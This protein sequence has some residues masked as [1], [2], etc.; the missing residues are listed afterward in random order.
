M[1]NHIQ[2]GKAWKI[3]SILCLHQCQTLLLLLI[4]QTQI[5]TVNHTPPRADYLSN[6]YHQCKWLM[7][8]I[9]KIQKLALRWKSLS[10]AISLM[11]FH[12]APQQN[13]PDLPDQ[14]LN[15]STTALYFFKQGVSTGLNYG[16]V[17]LC[18]TTWWLGE[19]HFVLLFLSLLLVLGIS[20]R[21]STGRQ[22][23]RGSFCRQCCLPLRTL[24]YS[25]IGKS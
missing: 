18:S 14:F 15:K 17:L 16:H 5:A 21:W 12:S 23:E 11:N 13:K 25:H 3:C 4:E 1:E 8:L 10:V 2:S 6:V 7:Y 24:P 22:R 20:L 9:N 19:P